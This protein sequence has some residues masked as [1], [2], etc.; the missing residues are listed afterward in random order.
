MVTNTQRIDISQHYSRS[1]IVRLLG[2]YI[3]KGVAMDD[4]I[5]DGF[6]ITLIV[7]GDKIFVRLPN[8][9][10]AIAERQTEE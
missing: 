1:H 5:S 6:E 3:P 8:W 7:K 2:Q 10:I 9:E 4:V